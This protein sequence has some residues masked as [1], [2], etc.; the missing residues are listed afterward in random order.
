MSAAAPPAHAAMRGESSPALMRID[1]RTRHGQSTPQPP[2]TRT[3][4]A[5]W[6]RKFR[7]PTRRRRDAEIGRGGRV[8]GLAH[9]TLVV[10]RDQQNGSPHTSPVKKDSPM[11]T[12]VID[13]L[14]DQLTL[15]SA[16]QNMPHHAN[17]SG[18]I[19][20]LELDRLSKTQKGY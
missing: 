2:S 18:T 6:L 16:S 1:Q 20:E 5:D 8:A 15:M 12:A 4:V 11:R 9:S 14:Y 7:Q 17:A 10:E 3:I 19:L 13:L